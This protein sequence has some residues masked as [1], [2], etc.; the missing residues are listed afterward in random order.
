MDAFLTSILLTRSLETPIQLQGL[1]LWIPTIAGC[2]RRRISH[3]HECLFGSTGRHEVDFSRADR[4]YSNVSTTSGQ[5]CCLWLRLAWRNLICLGEGGVSAHSALSRN[6]DGEPCLACSSVSKGEE[7]HEANS[8][9]AM[10]FQQR[11][12]YTG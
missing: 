10:M 6:S 5:P 3:L 11:L 8:T 2:T 9:R 12:R 1:F 4:T 7:R